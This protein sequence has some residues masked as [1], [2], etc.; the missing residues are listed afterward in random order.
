[1]EDIFA[2]ASKEELVTLFGNGKAVEML[3]E[4]QR[5]GNFDET[6]HAY[7]ARLYCLR[8]DMDKCDAHIQA[9]KDDKYRE[10]VQMT[11]RRVYTR[12]AK[13]PLI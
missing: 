4:V 7:L 1:M 11:I 5:L 2:I 13:E 3:K 8:G 10:G 12:D 9:I 6:G